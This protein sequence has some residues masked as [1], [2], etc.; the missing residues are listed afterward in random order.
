MANWGIEISSLARKGNVDNPEN[1]NIQGNH[2]NTE[3]LNNQGVPP[4]I[5]ARPVRDVAVPLTANLASSIRKPPP[6]GRFELKQS[7]AARWC[8]VCGGGNHEAEQCEENPD[9]VNYVGNAQ[10]DQGQQNYGNSYNPSWRN[11]PNFSLGGNQNQNQSQGVNQYRTQGVG[12]QYQNPNQSVNPS[13][14]KGGMTNEELFQKLMTE[15]GTKVSARIDK[16]DENIRNIQMS[17]MSLEKQV[18]Q[19]AN[20]LNLHPQGGLPGDTEPNPK[21]L[22][23]VSTR[24]GLQLHELAPKKRDTEVSTKDKKGEEVVK[25]SNVEAPIPQKKLPPPF[26]QR[27]KKQNEDECFGKFLS[28]LKQRFTEYKTVALTE[29]CS[30][31]IQNKLPKKLKDPG[32]FTVQIT[33]GQSVHARELCDLG[34]SINLMPLS[35]YLKLGLGS[36]KRTTVILQLADRSIARP[37]GVVED[38]LVQVCSLIF[39]VDFVVLDFEP[40]S[41][42]SFILGR[43]FL[44]T[45]R[46]LIDVAAGQLTMRAHDKVEAFD[47]YRP[48]KLPFIYEESSA[49]TVVD[50]IGI[51]SEDPLER[52]LVGQELEGDTEAQE[53][54][55]Y[56]NLAVVET[57]RTQVE[58]LDRELGSPPKPSIEE[59]PKLE[60][61]ALSAH[62]RYAYLG[63]NE[64]LPA[65][66]SA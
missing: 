57:R 4:I 36:P 35:L 58:S 48:L 1:V 10:R 40:D 50:Y 25:S 16:Q 34:E 54:E 26:T 2:N 18:A 14:P 55:S 66:L 41:K 31:R 6:G 47:V 7:M 20:Y 63:T 33:I 44:A 52:V 53:T 49:I 27:L 64:T 39:L 19:V 11:H 5:P 32:S 24:R 8:E 30:S 60:L 46:A 38:V 45:G 43:P 9:S 22:H 61:K 65:I 29:K 28:L 42:V 37:E 21:Q 15:I 51:V 3:N 56:L 13:A 17:Q 23:A 62:L 59:A 12:Q